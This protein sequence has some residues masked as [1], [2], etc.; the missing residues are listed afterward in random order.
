MNQEEKCLM[1]DGYNRECSYYLSVNNDMCNWSKVVDRDL[2]KIQRGE[3]NLAF[4]NL[5]TIISRR[6]SK[7]ELFQKRTKYDGI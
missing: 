3:T 6:L 2:D 5:E 7:Q 1:C 4:P